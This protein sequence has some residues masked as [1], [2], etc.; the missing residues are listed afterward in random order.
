MRARPR[1]TVEFRPEVL[2][3]SDIAGAGFH[4]IPA[5]FSTQKLCRPAMIF[6]ANYPAK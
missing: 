3:R 4:L 6:P 2:R 1:I 5:Y